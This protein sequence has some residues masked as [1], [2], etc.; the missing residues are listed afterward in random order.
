MAELTDIPVLL[1]NNTAYNSWFPQ[2]PFG[3][4]DTQ[5]LETIEDALSELLSGMVEEVRKGRIKVLIAEQLV[6][7][8]KNGLSKGFDDFNLDY[9]IIKEDEKDAKNLIQIVQGDI[10]TEKYIAGTAALIM[11]GCNKANIHPIT[12]GITGVE[13][14]IASQ[15]SQVEREKVSFRTRETKLESWRKEFE[16][17]FPILL[18]LEDILKNTKPQEYKVKIEFG[19][20]SNPTRES[21]IDMLNKAV[22]AGVLSIWEA[23]DEYYGE[24]IPE[25]EK[26]ERYIRTLVEK[27]IPLTDAQAAKYNEITTE[28]TD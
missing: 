26:E 16:R 14:I 17:F 5:G 21:I 3:E 1:K 27:G 20:F 13:S 25:D 2:S 4:A 23:Q 12:V 18:Q 28:D 15:E 8:D 7:K 11:Y 24:D 10:N 6:P 19:N 22:T 9:E